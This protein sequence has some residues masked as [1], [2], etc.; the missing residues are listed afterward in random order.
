MEHIGDT[1]RNPFKILVIKPKLKMPRPRFK[2]NIKK[3]D[4]RVV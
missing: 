3:Y 4:C 1:T 2:D